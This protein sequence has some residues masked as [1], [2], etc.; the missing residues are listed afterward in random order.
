LGVLFICPSSAHLLSLVF[1][2]KHSIVL[3]W[4]RS[5]ARPVGDE[6]R[7]SVGNR[8]ER[9]YAATMR[10]PRRR[11]GRVGHCRIPM[12]KTQQLLGLFTFR[13]VCCF[14]ATSNQYSAWIFNVLR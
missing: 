3:A 12:K 9:Q 13:C 11:S 14:M 10:V 2:V 6:A 1:S 5:R 8:K 7:R 4:D